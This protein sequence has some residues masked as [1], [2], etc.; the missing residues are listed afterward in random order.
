M[1][2]NREGIW[3]WIDEDGQKR[4]VVVY[5]ALKTV[6]RQFLRVYWW[7]GYYNVDDPSEWPERWGKYI[8]QDGSVPDKDLYLGPTPE[9]AQRLR[10][11]VERLKDIENE[12]QPR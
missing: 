11:L 1:K 3:E 10:E 2:P 12:N 6:G 7:G 4:L 8:G 5:N 9:Q